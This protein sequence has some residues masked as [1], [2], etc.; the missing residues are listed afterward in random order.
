MKGAVA[1][2][3]SGRRRILA[4]VG[5]ALSLVTLAGC[6]SDESPAQPSAAPNSASSAP[7]SEF[8]PSDADRDPSE[9]I[10]GIKI[11]SYDP[12]LHL[13]TPQRVAYD[14]SP[15]FGGRHDAVW[16]ACNGVVY[17]K[18]VRTEHM[19]HSMEHGALWVAYNPDQVSGAQLDSLKARVEGR[20]YTMMSPYPGLDQPISLQTWGHQLKVGAADDVRVN[21]FFTAL[22]LNK[23][24]YPEVGAPCDSGA[25]DSDNP[26]P[27]D[28][29]PPG[30]DAAPPK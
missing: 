22:T 5:A 26:P 29:T 1:M 21:Q 13:Q 17:S 12:G 9:R 30:A 4:L 25:F 18:A 10:Q 3:N 7:K 23:Y 24:T 6:T 11:E 15:P 16:A 8:T 19:V 28:P 2:A 27:F 14:Y 20:P